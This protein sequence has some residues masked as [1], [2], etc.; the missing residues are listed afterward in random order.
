MDILSSSSSIYITNTDN[1]PDLLLVW[2]GDT[3]DKLRLLWDEC[4]IHS[5]ALSSATTLAWCFLLYLLYLSCTVFSLFFLSV[6]NLLNLCTFIPPS[7]NSLAVL[8]S[9]IF[10]WRKSFTLCWVLKL[11]GASLFAKGG[12]HYIRI[13]AS[14]SK[15]QW[16]YFPFLSVPVKIVGIIFVATHLLI[17]MKISCTA[18]WKIY[19]S[20]ISQ[21]WIYCS[22]SSWSQMRLPSI[23]THATST[24]WTPSSLLVLLQLS[25]W[26]VDI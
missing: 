21:S 10:F 26:H 12:Q 14:C 5:A 16:K 11:C 13:H 19:G 9:F 7:L 3:T 8:P 24:Y 4:K 17:Q 25:M 18:A 20:I 6:F 1:G 2:W 23:T 22:E 15:Y